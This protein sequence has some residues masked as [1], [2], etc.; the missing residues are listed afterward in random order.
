MCTLGAALPVGVGSWK[1]ALWLGVR[2]SC[3]LHKMETCAELARRDT[4]ARQE[5]GL[6]PQLW[7]DVKSTHNA[8]VL[9]GA[10]CIPTAHARGDR[11]TWPCGRR[12]CKAGGWGI[13]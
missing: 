7:V 5:E 2:T 6:R 3:T 10:P 4:D 11:N 12:G 9:E 8:D 13:Q 1:P